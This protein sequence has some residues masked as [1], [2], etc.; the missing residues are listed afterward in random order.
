MTADMR[1]GSWGGNQLSRAHY[2]CSAAP[3]VWWLLPG[4]LRAEGLAVTLAPA[5]GSTKPR[6]HPS[7]LRAGPGQSPC[8]P[9][10]RGFWQLPLC[11]PYLSPYQILLSGTFFPRGVGDQKRKGLLF[12]EC[13]V[14]P[15]VGARLGAVQ[16]RFHPGLAHGPAVTESLSASSSSS[17]KGC[18][19]TSEAHCKGDT[20]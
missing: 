11:T 16:T 1:G 17:V 6:A 5:A 8:W 12:A 4:A 15:C 18:M 3:A 19:L 2:P 14:A 20:R 9:G 13:P 7:V 10:L